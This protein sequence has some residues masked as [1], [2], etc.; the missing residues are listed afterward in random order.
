MVVCRA[1]A[2]WSSRAGFPYRFDLPA[3]RL[4][5]DPRRLLERAAVNQELAAVLSESGFMPEQSG[6]SAAHSALLQP[7]AGPAWFAVGDAACSLTSAE[8]RWLSCY[9]KK[10]PLRGPANRRK[11]YTITTACITGWSG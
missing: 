1:H 10:V 5:A 7:F 8:M 4:V 2:G 3:A 9:Y 11:V 6:F